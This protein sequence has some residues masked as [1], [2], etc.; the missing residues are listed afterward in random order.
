MK[1]V[2]ET[3]IKYYKIEELLIVKNGHWCIEKL[4]H[5]LFYFLKFHACLTSSF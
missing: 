2:P 5:T 3:F 4:S 1:L